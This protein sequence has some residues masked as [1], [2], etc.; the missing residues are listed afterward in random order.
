VQR[1]HGKN[2]LILSFLALV[3]AVGGCATPKAAA[4]ETAAAQTPAAAA[5]VVPARDTAVRPTAEAM[6]AETAAP[7]AAA[8]S[9]VYVP[10]QGAAA[11]PAVAAAETGLSDCFFAYDDYSLTAEAKS[12]LA[13]DAKYLKANPALRVKIEGHCDERGTSEYNLGLGERRAASA[14]GYLVSL[15][16]DGSR[17]ETISYGK[18]RPFDPG[19]TEEAWAKNRRAHFVVLGR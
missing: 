13:A 19:H 8:A 1:Y 16:I 2:V 14:R 3:I 5:P 9:P 18:E 4:P 12:I 7:V 6:P 15:G 17:L 10:G 11:A